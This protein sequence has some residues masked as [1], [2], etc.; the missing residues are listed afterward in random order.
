M[1]FIIALLMTFTLSACLGSGGGGNKDA[2][3]WDNDPRLDDIRLWAHN[4]GAIVT[5]QDPNSY[6]PP[7]QGV[8]ST[9]GPNNAFGSYYESGGWRK[10]R[11][12]VQIN[13][14]TEKHVQDIMAHEMGHY[15]KH[16]KTGD[17]SGETY[18]NWVNTEIRRLEAEGLIPSAPGIN[19]DAVRAPTVK[20]TT[21][22]KSTKVRRSNPDDKD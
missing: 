9:W 4:G 13:R 22:K 7:V 12:R 21:T 6:V 1:K 5:D 16:M 3:L 14:P 17:P 18:A 8:D 11:I 2:W 20:A 15:F 19:W 10:S